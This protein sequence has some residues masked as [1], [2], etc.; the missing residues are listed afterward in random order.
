[1][2]SKFTLIGIVAALA[3]LAVAVYWN[4]ARP[5]TAVAEPSGRDA[6]NGDTVGSASLP[7]SGATATAADRARWAATPLPPLDTPLRT[8]VR[9]L[10]A[11]AKA[12]DARA[13]CR[14][15]AEYQYCADLQAR[16]QMIESGVA[17]AQARSGDGPGPGRGSR[18]A[19]RMAAAFDN[20]NE[21]YQHCEGVAVPA[22]TDI[23]RY[24]RGAAAAGHPQASGYYVSGE[25]FRNRD[26]IENL[27]ELMLYRDQAETLAR[28]AVDRGDLRA[29]WALVEAYAA[30]PSDF[31]RSLL[32]QAVEPAPDRALALL[33]GLRA[34]TTPAAAADPASAQIVERLE[35]RIAGLEQKLPQADVA[36][37][38]SQPSGIGKAAA[39]GDVQALAG[40][41]FSRGR[42]E[43][44][45]EICD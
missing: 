35:E 19:E 7:A 22:S 31:R 10:T 9:E 44:R 18:S 17:R 15:A 26:T 11:R 42:E 29:A 34:S 41:M 33:Y 45:R 16:M 28:T 40:A 24:M 21:R 3:V 23:V 27:N 38:R 39:A 25:M 30:D 12:G 37:L 36:R 13:M 5:D 6:P 14:L 4:R 8:V 2:R 20:V 1:M 32:A 43:F